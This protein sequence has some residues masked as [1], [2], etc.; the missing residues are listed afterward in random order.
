MK[1]RLEISMDDG[2]VKETEIMGEPTPEAILELVNKLLSLHTAPQVASSPQPDAGKVRSPQTPQ[3][4]VTSE[5]IPTTHFSQN[6]LQTPQNNQPNSKRTR[7]KESNSPPQH[8]GRVN[9]YPARLEMAEEEYSR[10]KN[11]SLTIKERLE[12]FLNFEY[13]EQW[14]TSL[15]VKKDY[16]RTY[17]NINLSTVSTYLSRMY[18]EGKLERTGNR[19]QRKYRVRGEPREQEFVVETYSPGLQLRP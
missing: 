9:N 16:D 6:V 7:F 2:S 8:P 19:N 17:G 18:R 14:F 5:Q 15:E 12:L 13:E 1:I 11:E 4:P 3:P 10:L